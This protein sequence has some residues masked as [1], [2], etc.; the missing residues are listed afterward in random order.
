M[1]G[2]HRRTYWDETCSPGNFPELNGDV[3][4]DVAII[5]G[6]MVGVC[7]ARMIKDAGMIAAVI[8][9]RRIGQGASGRAT[10]KVTSQHG[11]RYRTIEKKF[12]EEQARLYAEAQEAGLSRIVE[13]SRTHGIDADLETRPA[14]VY[15]RDE[16]HVGDI[17]K[18][19]EV[20]RKLGL[21]AQLTRETGLPFE[22]KAA[23]RWDNQAQL[24]PIKF[25]AG[26]AQT[27]PGEGSHVFENSRVTDWDPRRIATERGTVRARHVVMATNLPLGQVGMYYATNYPM[28]EPVI[29]APLRQA[30]PG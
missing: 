13:L 27:I 28:A 3:E 2:Y 14:Y 1:A 10:A 15:T 17:E 7:A 25:V 29:A 21:P 18:E 24:H 4:V 26:L 19:V 6:G 11:I 8:E 30:L 22:V 16:Q 12:G 9:A 23:M 20:A 5:G